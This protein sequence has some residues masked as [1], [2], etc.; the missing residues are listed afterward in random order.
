[1]NFSDAPE[2]R[3]IYVNY[4]GVPFNKHNL[5][6]SCYSDRDRSRPYD[7]KAKSPGMTSLHVAEALCKAADLR[8][9]VLWESWDCDPELQQCD[10]GVLHPVRWTGKRVVIYR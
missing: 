8:R 4:R 6:K 2:V 5:W 9:D 7:P 3:K 10:F 1:M